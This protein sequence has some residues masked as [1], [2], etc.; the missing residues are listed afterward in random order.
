M[1]TN[2]LLFAL[3]FATFFS[4]GSILNSD[5]INYREE[6]RSFVQ[7][8]SLF[9]KKQD[10]DFIIIPQNGHQLLVKNGKPA[11]NYLNAIDGLGQESLF[12]GYENMDLPTP[13]RATNELLNLLNLGEKAGK[14]VL[15]TDYCT[16]PFKV[17]Q[18]YAQNQALGYLSFAA[19]VRELSVIPSNPT[20]LPGENSNTI[21][22]LSQAK[23]FLY[24][25]NKK[26]YGDKA[27]FISAI[28]KTNYD[29]IIIDAFFNSHMLTA[30]DVE[31]LKKKENGGKRLVISY[32]SIG[33]A[34][35]YRYYWQSSWEPGNPEWLVMENPQWAGN[36]KVK[37]W[38]PEWQDII[39]GNEN[40]Y[41]QQILDAGFDGAY[42]DII[43]GF[44]FF[45]N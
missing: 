5:G 3:L 42:L 7:N 1:R 9:A 23:N 13:A 24:L 11:N 44:D 37:Y 33:E 45:E 20:S 16:T 10:A 4:C 21:T 41:L 36:Y 6:M 15:V 27:D 8:I 14:T 34:E 32:M 38:E 29:V 40:S 43:D 30:T 26:N 12:F 25:L 17:N 35:T 22:K 19:P 2:L 28:Q 31:Q 39:Y 18:S